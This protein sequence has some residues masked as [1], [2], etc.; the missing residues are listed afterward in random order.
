[1]SLAL[2][3]YM[4]E[5][6][7]ASSELQELVDDRI[8]DQVPPQ[9]VMPYVT[10]GLV[11]E[12]SE[13]IGTVDDDCSYQGVEGIAQID[14]WS[15][16]VGYPGVKLIAEACRRAFPT[17]LPAIPGLALTEF[18]FDRYQVLRDPDGM[19]SHAV[20]EYRAKYQYALS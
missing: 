1:M 13:Q 3:G 6:L 5:T 14:C 8:Y 7:G 16:T 12:T 20:I 2:Q 4:R 11:Q 9:A 18:M 19:T 10:I 15:R 17:N